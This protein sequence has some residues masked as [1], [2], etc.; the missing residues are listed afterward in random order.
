[1][2]ENEI[3]NYFKDIQNLKDAKKIYKTLAKKLHPDIGGSEEAFKL[4]QKVFNDYKKNKLFFSDDI[5]FN[6]EI[7]KIITQILHYDNIEIEVIFKW[8]WISGDTKVI[9]EHLKELGFR[10]ASKKK[11]WYYGEL[12][13]SRSRKEQSIQSIRSKY[14]TSKVAQ[15]Q[16]QRLK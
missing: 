6:I 2:N 4:L 5:K 10:Y 9:K 7:E 11:M 14:G 3:K 12:Q 8:I 1:M 15:T 13:K 16:T